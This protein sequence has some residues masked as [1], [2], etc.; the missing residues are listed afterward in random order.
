MH[1]RSTTRTNAR[2]LTLAAHPAAVPGVRQRTCEVVREWDLGE[3]SDTVALLV[4]ELVTNA[5]RASADDGAPDDPAEVALT[6]WRTG[7][8]LGIE[9]WDD[10]PDPAALLRP[11]AD[12]ESGRGL[13]IVE[14]LASRWGQHAVDGGKVVWCELAVAPDALPVTTLDAGPALT[15]G[16]VALAAGPARA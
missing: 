6:I 14:A 3:L 1:Q 12:T 9:V 4:S 11:D 5:V 13:L 16:P 15:A 2:R 8:S 7:G 10:R